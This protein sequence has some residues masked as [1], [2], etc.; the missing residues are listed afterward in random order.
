MKKYLVIGGGVIVLLATAVAGYWFFIHEKE[1]PPRY[2]RDP[3]AWTVPPV[4]YPMKGKTFVV[5][6]VENTTV[7]LDL[8]FPS[9]KHDYPMGRF[10]L[11]SGTGEGQLY[12]MDDLATGLE[13]GLRAVPVV[14]TGAGSGSFTYL[15]IIEESDTTFAHK[16]SLFLGDRIRIT[17]VTRSGNEVTVAYGVHDHNQSMAEVPAIATTAIIDIANGTFVQEGRKPW[18]EATQVAKSFAGKYLWQKTVTESGE[19]ITPSTAGVFS[20]LFDGPRI[21][22]GTDCNTGSSEFTPPAGTSTSLTF[23][24]VASTKKFCESSEEGPYF[25]MITA[26]RAYEEAEDG[27]LTFTLTDGREMVF[28]REGQVLEFAPE[29]GDETLIE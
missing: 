10:A 18:I 19:E 6:E 14:V 3:N 7:T 23:G 2:T 8:I 20:L 1:K 21:T 16:K 24:A 17:G 22:L 13:N 27:T 5:P 15:A 4:T 26:V 28:V 9:T 29:E 25:E 11:A 12:A